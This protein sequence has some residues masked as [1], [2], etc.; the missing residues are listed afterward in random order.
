[1]LILQYLSSLKELTVLNFLLFDTDEEE[2]YIVSNV[3]LFKRRRIVALSWRGP[4]FWI[5]DESVMSQLFVPAAFNIS[6]TIYPSVEAKCT[7]G[8]GK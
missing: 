1:M 5:S 8:V 6:C 3:L 4:F 7:L 2:I